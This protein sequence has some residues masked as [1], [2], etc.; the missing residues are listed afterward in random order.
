MGRDVDVQDSPSPVLDHEPHV[1]ESKASGR[2]Y[3]EV[4]RGDRIPVVAKECGPALPPIKVRLAFRQVARDGGEADAEAEHLEFSLDLSRSPTVLR[5]EPAD[6]PLELG[7]D[8]RATWTPV[9]HGSPIEAEAPPVPPHDGL[10]LDDDESGRPL[11]P[12]WG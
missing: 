11:R 3:E 12:D 7:R 1:E 2:D 5:G 6:E 8:R 10:R 9:R 4:H